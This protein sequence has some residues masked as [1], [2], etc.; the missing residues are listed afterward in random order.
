[1]IEQLFSTLQK[2]SDFL[3]GYIGAA[4]IIVAGVLVSHQ[5]GWMQLKGLP[6]MIR[7]GLSLLQSPSGKTQ[8][9]RGVLPRQAFFASLGGCVGVG[10]VVAV[11]LAVQVGGPGVLVWL[12]IVALLG[13]GL[14]YGEVYLGM[15]HRRPSKDGSYNGG[16]MYVLAEAFSSCKGWL[17]MFA[18]V[19]LCIYGTEIY[20][21]GVIKEAVATSW[22]LPPAWVTVVL[23]ALVVLGVAGGVKRIGTI[24]GVLLPFFGLLFLVMTLWVLVLH[25]ATIPSLLL[26][27][28]RSAFTGHAAVGGFVGSTFMLTMSRGVF[29]ACYSGDVGIGYASVIHSESRVQDPAQQASLSI[30]GIFLDTTICT[31]VVLLLLLT[32]AWQQPGGSSTLVQTALSSTF[33]YMHIFMPLLIFSFGYTTIMAYLIAGIKSARFLSAKYGSTV[34]W[35]CSTMAFIGF[36]VWDSTRALVVMELAGG[37]LMIINCIALLRLR[38]S[39]QAPC[40]E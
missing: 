4:M 18:A 31:C 26:S 29:A 7:V 9:D 22:S 6:R 3:W 30:L 8:Q 1:M 2:T 39:I 5:L 33:P 23:L 24:S 34:Y 15:A 37:L 35:I 16:P 20:I 32:G 28:F 19:L 14:K 12:W 10:N 25:A 21:F 38:R 17:P 13:M 36:S 27:V 11:T 40:M